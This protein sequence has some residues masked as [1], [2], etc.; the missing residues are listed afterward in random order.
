MISLHDVNLNL[1][2][3]I[4]ALEHHQNVSRAGEASNISQSA[5]SD[6]LAQLR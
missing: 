5:V 1:P 4:Q 2:P 6:A 3:V